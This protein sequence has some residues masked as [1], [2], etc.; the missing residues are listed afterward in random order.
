MFIHLYGFL[1]R[2]SKENDDRYLSNALYHALRASA[3][4][5]RIGGR[6]EESGLWPTPED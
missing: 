1:L 4:T 6:K 3:A 5:E 2:M